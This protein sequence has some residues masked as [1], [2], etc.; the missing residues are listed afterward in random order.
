MVPFRKLTAKWFAFVMASWQVSRCYV[1]FRESISIHVCR[2]S[3]HSCVE[4]MNLNLALSTP[5]EYADEHG[6]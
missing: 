1:S 2:G 4:V 3:V 6:A 5:T